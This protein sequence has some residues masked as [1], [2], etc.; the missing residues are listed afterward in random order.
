M[1]STVASRIIRRMK[2]FTLALE[3]EMEDPK[4]SENVQQWIQCKHPEHS[5]LKM[6]VYPPGAFNDYTCPA[7]GSVTRFMDWVTYNT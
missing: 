7:C 1:K 3:N 6:I 2:E 5:P 4:N